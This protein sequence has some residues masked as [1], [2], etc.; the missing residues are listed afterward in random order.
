MVTTIV[1]GLVVLGVVLVALALS[2]LVSR[3]RP[4]RRAAR[5]LGWRAEEAQRLQVKAMAVQETMADLQ[6]RIDEA[7]ARA[8]ALSPTPTSEN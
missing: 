7:A 2:S 3:A 5:R 4:L 8:A 6:H 1:L